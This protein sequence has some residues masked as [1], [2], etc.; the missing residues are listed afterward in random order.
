MSFESPLAPAIPT[1]LVIR[2]AASSD[3]P[4][5]T[6]IYR[7]HVQT[8]TASFEEIPPNEGEIANRF[9]TIRD[10][11]LPYLVAMRSDVIAGY[12]YASLY[13]PRSAY[14][15]T[16]ENSI[17]VAPDCIGGGI[18]ATLMA[19]LLERCETGPWQQMIAVIGDS[20]NHA[21]IALHRKFGFEMTG[22]FHKVG[23]KFGRWLDSILMQRSLGTDKPVLPGPV[24]K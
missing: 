10:H 19:A 5:I 2:D 11:G 14:R 9:T 18:G 1:K 4:A 13:R 23:Y 7:H 17:Y 3:I 6:A 15:H 24:E 22:T 21:S 16:I 12:C 20:H 8:G